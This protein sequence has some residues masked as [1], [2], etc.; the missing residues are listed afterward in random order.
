MLE[1]ALEVATDP[2]YKFDLS[3]QLG[4]LD[5]AKVDLVVAIFASSLAFLFVWKS[6]GRNMTSRNP[7]LH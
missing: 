6:V 7:P 1:D 3:V 2:D 4:R 5:V